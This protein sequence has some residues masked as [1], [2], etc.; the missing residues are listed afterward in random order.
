MNVRI[1]ADVRIRKKKMY[2]G[3]REIRGCIFPKNF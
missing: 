1:A 3:K 2:E